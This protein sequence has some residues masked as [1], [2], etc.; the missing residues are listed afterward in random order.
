M[1]V[2]CPQYWNKKRTK[3]L[4]V[5]QSFKGQ[6]RVV[7]IE[8]EGDLTWYVSKCT[9]PSW[10]KNYR[11]PDDA[12]AKLIVYAVKNDLVEVKVNAASGAGTPSAA[13][14]NIQHHYE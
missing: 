5:Q 2:V 13:R 9:K 3:I 7:T 11:Y 6:W 4:R 1:N 10:A 12:V 14:E 8:P